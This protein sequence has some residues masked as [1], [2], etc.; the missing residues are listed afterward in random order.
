MVEAMEGFKTCYECGEKRKEY[1]RA[2]WTKRMQMAIEQILARE[3]AQGK[4][5]TK[6]NFNGMNRIL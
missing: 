4:K 6:N 1:S 3:E 5:V 2:Y